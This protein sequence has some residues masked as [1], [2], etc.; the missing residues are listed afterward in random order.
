MNVVVAS[1][2][3]VVGMVAPGRAEESAIG[4]ETTAP[5]GGW[6]GEV[7]DVAG[8]SRPHRELHEA[9]VPGD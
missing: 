3:A 7:R 6:V 2:A 1:A 5:G 9:G 4:K 8:D